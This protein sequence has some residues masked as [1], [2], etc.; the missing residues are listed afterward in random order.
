[1]N[2]W[3]NVS[4]VLFSIQISAVLQIKWIFQVAFECFDKFEEE[5][6][7]GRNRGREKAHKDKIAMTT[8]QSINED[9]GKSNTRFLQSKVVSF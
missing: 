3:N 8:L 1:M 7:N 4:L 6:Q 5:F 9:D 2:Q